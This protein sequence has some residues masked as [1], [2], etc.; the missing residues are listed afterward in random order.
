MNVPTD[1][2]DLVLM[3]FVGWTAGV[4]FCI[5]IADLGVY[6]REPGGKLR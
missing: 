6:L 5:V 3:L 2:Y 4:I 1:T